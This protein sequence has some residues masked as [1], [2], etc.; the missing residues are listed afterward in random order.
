VN[1]VKAEDVLASPCKNRKGDMMSCAFSSTGDRFTNG[2]WTTFQNLY[3]NELMRYTLF[4]TYYMDQIRNSTEREV[5]RVWDRYSD[6]VIANQKEAEQLSREV[7]FAK[8]AMYQTIRRL[9]NL[10]TTFP[11]HIGLMAYLE[12]LEA[13]RKVFV[14]IYTPLQQLSSLRP[15]AQ[16]CQK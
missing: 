6:A 14:K 5:L 12:D 4:S 3:M 16:S 9:Q 13:Y 10:Y 15:D 7:V 8:E 1:Y 2:D 11:I